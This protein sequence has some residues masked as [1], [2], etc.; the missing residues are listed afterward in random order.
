MSTQ[1]D[2]PAPC[3]VWRDVV[4][5]KTEQALDALRGADVL[6]ESLLG[7]PH[8]VSGSIPRALRGNTRT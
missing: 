6:I 3:G 2:R 5:M 8:G 7:K 4:A 1:V